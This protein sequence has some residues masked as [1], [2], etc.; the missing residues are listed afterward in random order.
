MLGSEEKTLITNPLIFAL[1]AGFGIF[2]IWI[3]WKA[4]ESL[5]GIEKSLKTIAAAPQDRT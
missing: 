4:F 1:A 2:F 3:L 5:K